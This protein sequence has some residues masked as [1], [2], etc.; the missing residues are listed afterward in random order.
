MNLEQLLKDYKN[1]ITDLDSV[2]KELARLPYEDLDFAKLD[3]HRKL[4][5]GYGEVVY[6]SGK[7][8]EHLV[9]VFKHFA[10]EGTNVLGS[11]ASIEQYEAVRQVL[12]EVEYDPV[13]GIMK[14]IQEDTKHNIGRK[15][16]ENSSKKNE[17]AIGNICVCTDGT[18]DVPVAEE[19]AQTAEFFGNHVTRIYDVG[20]AGIH[21]LLDNL[22]TI[23]QANC[24]IADA[25]MEGA[26]PG[27]IAGLV[28]VPVIGVPTSVGY[29][30][31]YGGA[32]A[33]LTMLNSC[34][35]GIATVNIDNGFGA[36]YIASQ[37]N[38]QTVC[39]RL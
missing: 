28:Q 4:R 11:R 33:I 24:I 22:E 37:I 2:K 39:G 10:E 14:Y 15:S 8:T 17:A 32:A 18:A 25:G 5:T 31:G 7:V 3:H 34:S 30:T 9:A 1:G 12:P 38:H 26:L 13:S 27:V 35:N 19:A 29:G 36:A 16:K 21:R 23:Q 6:C 20:V